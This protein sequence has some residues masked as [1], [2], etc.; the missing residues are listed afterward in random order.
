[1][2]SADCHDIGDKM[3]QTIKIGLI[4]AVALAVHC[5]LATSYYVS[6]VGADGNSGTS[7]GAP[8]LTISK[9][10]GTSF[11]QGDVVSFR[12]GDTFAGTLTP[13]SG[14][15]AGKPIVF[16]S[17]GTGRAVIN[18]GN[19]GG[20]TVGFS[21]VSI[22]NLSFVGSG[23]TSGNTNQG[24]YISAPYVLVDHVEVQGFEHC[25][26]ECFVANLTLRYVYAHDNGQAG[27]YVDG[28][29]Y[30]PG[31]YIG[32]CQADNNAGDPSITNNGSGNGIILG[33]Q[34]G[35]LVEY[36]EASTN[37]YAMPWNG[38]GPA[39]I[40]GYALDHV[41]FQY[42]IAHDNKTPSSMDGDGF[43]LDGGTHSSTYQYCLA[44]NNDGAG[45]LGWQY[46]N[47]GP[48]TNNTFYNSRSGATDVELLNSCPGSLFANNIFVAKS[49][50]FNNSGSGMSYEGNCYWQLNG[51]FSLD[52][53]SSF[54][55][56]AAGKGQETVSNVLVGINANPQLVNPTALMTLSDPTQLAA[57]SAFQLNTNSP[58]INAG[59]NL[60]SIYAI[61]PGP[62][63]F[64]GTPIPQGG[65]Y[66]MGACEFN[67]NGAP[68]AN[69]PATSTIY[70]VAAN[71]GQV[72]LTWS[73]VPTATNYIVKRST[74]SGAEV[75]IATT[76]STSYT[77][78][79]IVNGTTYYYEVTAANAYGTSGNSGE[80]SATPPVPPPA[81]TVLVDFDTTY[82]TVS[83]DAN[84]LYWNNIAAGQ[85]GGGA[86][87]LN[88]S[89]SPVA[90]TNL[91]DVNSGW[92]LAITNL[93]GWSANAAASWQNYGGPYPA[94]LTNF[95]QTA[96][97]NGMTIGGSGITVT[98]SGLTPGSIYNLLTYGA[99]GNS[100][101]MN[102]TYQTNT[103]TVGSSAS[104]ATA[105]FY[106]LNNATTVV[107]WTNVTPGAG[108]KIVLTIV[109]PDGGALNFMEIIPVP[110][111]APA[112]PT[113]LGATAGNGQVAL[114]WTAAI[115]AASYNVK[116][117]T[118]SGAETTIT[119]VT[120]VNYTDTQVVNGTTYYY[121]VSATN[122]YGESPNSVEVSAMPQP[123]PPPTPTGLGATAGNA[124]VAL[125]WTASA[126][127]TSYNVK[128]STTSG[129]ETTITNVTGVNYT[130][131]NVVNNT[132]YYYKV[133][134]TNSY[135]ESANS[136]EVSATPQPPPPPTPTGLGA[137]AGNGQVALAWTASTGATSYNVKRSITSGAETTITN[138]SG[139]N[140]TDAQAANNTTYY[141]EVSAV[142]AYGE[143]TNSVEVSATPKAPPPNPASTALLNFAGSTS[144]LVTSPDG[145]GNYWN[146]IGS[147]VN[148]GAGLN[149][150][151]NNGLGTHG[152]SLPL[153]SAANGNS[154]WTLSISNWTGSGIQGDSG[155]GSNATPYSTSLT[156][157]W[158]LTALE[159]GLAIHYNNGSNG[160]AVYLSGLNAGHTYNVL[161]YGYDP[162]QN[163]SQ[164]N[165]LLYGSS[166]SPNPVTFANVGNN[167][168]AWAEW[169]NITPT[170]GGQIVIGIDCGKNYTDGA[171]NAME[172]IQNAPAAVGSI[173]R[174]A[175]VGNSLT[176]NWTANANI[177]LQSATNL[178]PPV[179][180]TDVP[181]TTG[182]GS[183]TI[184][185]TNTRMFF[186]LGPP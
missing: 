59:L 173:A 32:Y 139:V 154:G 158:P 116:R 171:L 144:Y 29:A 157:I 34:T 44:Y 180:W 85:T 70:N 26:V 142:N 175:M 33:N 91:G 111:T 181:N 75:A 64:F 68:G 177:A 10:N 30:Q 148:F 8:W 28:A 168:N 49:S 99:N 147:G 66:D 25:G 60:H 76:P 146:N 186:R 83:P 115:G 93:S 67:T 160:V 109:A 69:P 114:T 37:G 185:T 169:D 140:Y 161:L 61:N 133:S 82:V 92:T 163:T 121:K 94:A 108:G 159:D 102:G 183:A 101:G 182:Q 13:A 45:F 86:V 9:V 110:T 14:G 136:V 95:P 43:D 27:I 53:Y 48:W 112:A 7:P 138:V 5:A 145:N 107:Q 36:C 47:V 155:H 6:A 125:T 77:D 42:C 167:T 22:T 128:R 21:Y 178:T 118:T 15:V 176:L 141:Y 166:A 150:L 73:A 71:S 179:V 122:A 130:D 120:G 39:G 50:V 164:T 124:Q 3:N 174:G 65:A 78:P 38:N 52:G 149:T 62:H 90:L 31:L 117:S 16:T 184:T 58:C 127:A 23:R 123:Q 89:L 103:L 40:W 134:A 35:A 41:M 96:V 153:V 87:Q 126:G 80:V 88:G 135:G 172:L 46:S 143:S 24:I 129:A 162:S 2:N 104:P 12:G 63:D 152:T 1:M 74:T 81:G 54:S 106:S 19:A 79:S 11:V 156:A 56:W 72:I 132:T 113:G 170:A 17:Y 151:T 84:G 98:L 105:S 4:M 137:T 119:N 18:G 20:C 165:T 57:L 51:A 55:S 100:Y 97:E 131:T